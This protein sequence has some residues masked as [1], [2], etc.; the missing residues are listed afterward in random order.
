MVSTSG[1]FMYPVMMEYTGTSDDKT[2]K[3]SR[4]DELVVGG[5]SPAEHLHLNLQHTQ[6]RTLY[7][8]D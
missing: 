2:K 1:Y 7:K 8:K 5:W 3:D 4:Y 6:S